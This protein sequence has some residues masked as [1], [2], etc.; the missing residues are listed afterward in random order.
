M[1]CEAEDTSSNPHP[2]PLFGYV[3]KK[4]KKRNRGLEGAPH[5]LKSPK[6]SQEMVEQN[7]Q[8]FPFKF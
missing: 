6:P 8:A 4:E 7:E 5:K 3:K 2:L 1:P